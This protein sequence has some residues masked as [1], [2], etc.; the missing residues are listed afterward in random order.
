MFLAGFRLSCLSTD[1]GIG[2]ISGRAHA[3]LIHCLSTAC[4]QISTS[5][6]LRCFILKPVG[7]PVQLFDIALKA[8][9]Q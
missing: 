7:R 8:L 4:Q 5:L 9:K 6:A 2:C 3:L 1:E